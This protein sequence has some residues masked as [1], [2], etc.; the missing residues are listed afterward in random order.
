MLCNTLVDPAC[1]A[2]SGLIGSLAGRVATGVLG[3]IAQAVT[4]GIRWIVI[5]T[6]AWWVQIPSPS[7]GAEP[8]VTHIQA[9]LL[10]IT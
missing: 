6:A 2:A 1:H 3:S 9:W 4:V 5:N 7:L 10:P 8:A